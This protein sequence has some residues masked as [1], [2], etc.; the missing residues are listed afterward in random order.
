M[1]RLRRL[2]ILA[3]LPLGLTFAC[4]TVDRASPPASATPLPDGEYS[5]R[6]YHHTEPVSLD[7]PSG[8]FVEEGDDQETLARLT[9][10]EATV[11]VT[12]AST[13]NAN[14]ASAQES[15][16]DFLESQ[17]PNLASLIEKESAYPPPSGDSGW[18]SS[19]EW[20]E[21]SGSSAAFRSST[22]VQGDQAFHLLLQGTPG[23]VEARLP[24]WEAI[25]ASLR[26]E[27]LEPMSVPREGTLYLAGSEPLTLDPALTHSGPAGLIGDLFS[28]L[29][30][31]DP[32]LQVRPA[33][34]LRWE[35]DSGG[36][37]YTFHLD[38]LARFHN[39]RPLTA[40]DVAFSWE[41]AAAP[42][43]G[44]ETAQLYLGDVEGVAEMQAG[45]AESLRGVLVLDA[46]TLQVTLLASRPYF[47]A[48]LTYPVA[49]V[50]DRENVAL[51]NWELHPNGSGPFRHVQHLQD[52]V[53]VVERNPFYN[54][55]APQLQRIVYQMY[56]GYMQQLYELDQ[57]DMTY[58]DVDQL[59]R[60]ADS[61]DSLF[62]T[63]TTES[64]LCTNYVTFNTRLAP[65]DD[66]QVR[67]AFAMATDRQRYVDAISDGRDLPAR[68]LLPPGMPGVS[69]AAVPLPY[70]PAAARALLD[71]TAWAQAGKGLI[72]WTLLGYGG[73]VAPA[74]EL[75]RDMWEETLA[76]EIQLEGIAWEDYYDRLDAGDYGQLLLE[77]WCAD[78]PDPEN[79][80]DLL[81]HSASAQNHSFYVSPE[82]DALVEA[83]RSAEGVE[84]RLS[85]Y[86]QAEALVLD[87]APF[88][89]LSHPGPDYVL[90]KPFVHGY[91]ASPI[92]VPQHQNLWLEN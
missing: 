46:H 15:N 84:A 60:A 32:A 48:K 73:R 14:G 3:A 54:G 40:E 67:R 6:Y 27:S 41:R 74:A 76:V 1:I 85:R 71:S 62:G 17:A 19:G 69:P 35:V 90:W 92:G 80:L 68:G 70:D 66:P 87:E 8:W 20:V 45:L 22:V 50:V 77:G 61:G 37:V 28:G 29:V 33:L 42:E 13:L 24:Q 11:V 9:D 78:Y 75:L 36:R 47:L 65:F 12:L 25:V 86:Q 4:A 72:T 5:V 82:F 55:A 52:E 51:P 89:P 58:L 31:M 26:F 2:W 56:A 83:G 79:F 38:P 57:A 30:S 43:T 18:T 10:A 39:G 64:G 91:L 59:E 81:F 53:F 21:S 63:V 88:I 7:I 16:Y 44:S 34:A 49:W 23:G